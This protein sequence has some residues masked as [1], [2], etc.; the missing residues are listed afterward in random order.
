[1]WINL[2]KSAD[3]AHVTCQSNVPDLWQVNGWRRWVLETLLRLSCEWDVFSWKMCKL[4]VF[5]SLGA[6]LYWV[7]VGHNDQGTTFEPE[8]SRNILF[9]TD[10]SDSFV[11]HKLHFPTKIFHSRHHLHLHYAWSKRMRRK[12][13]NDVFWKVVSSLKQI[14]QLIMHVCIWHQCS[15]D[16]GVL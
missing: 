4:K 1:M 12:D 3:V 14:K 6:V 13:V 7:W 11:L 8:S 9:L 16:I 15:F 5:K 10:M 2:L